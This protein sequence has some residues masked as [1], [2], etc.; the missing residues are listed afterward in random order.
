MRRFLIILIVLLL[1]NTLFAQESEII[2]IT[3]PPSPSNDEFYISLLKT[4]IKYNETCFEGKNEIIVQKESKTLDTINLQ[5]IRSRQDLKRALFCDIDTLRK[6]NKRLYYQTVLGFR[7]IIKADI[8]DLNDLLIETVKFGDDS[9]VSEKI[10]Y[11]YDDSKRC[12]SEQKYEYWSSLPDSNLILSIDYKFKNDKL[13]EQNSLSR[14]PYSSGRRIIKT[15]YNKNGQIIEIDNTL[16][17]E[18]DKVIWH[19]LTSM[20]YYKNGNLKDYS[21][22]EKEQIKRFQ[23]QYNADII[24]TFVFEEKKK[25]EYYDFKFE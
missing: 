5:M 21:F 12:I 6:S 24:K 25:R 1:R 14:K 22:T 17:S 8:F 19:S 9:L 20:D 16:Y 10:F 23:F 13:I 15:T 2:P 3:R 4:V 11:K 7:K 18:S